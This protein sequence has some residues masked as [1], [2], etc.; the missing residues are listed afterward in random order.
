MSWKT[1]FF[2]FDGRI[3]RKQWWQ[4][5][6]PLLFVS[7]TLAF[8]ANPRAWFFDDIA[9]AGPTLA[10]TLLNIAF[11]IP[12]TAI[13]VKRFNDRNWP[14]IL[15]YSYAFVFLIFVLL[16]HNR[17]IFARHTPS[18][19]DIAFVA[20]LAAIAAVVII[21]NG[22]MRGTVGPNQYGPDP[23]SHDGNTHTPPAKAGLKP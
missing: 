7:V 3:G 15:P 22:F 12:Q 13:C 18:Q 21:D 20:S 2:S 5:M 17:I 1:L 11:L 4:A 14:Q 10:E 9:R 16:D 6:V 23:L 8:L 19:L